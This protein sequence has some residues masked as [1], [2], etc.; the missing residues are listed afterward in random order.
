M[1]EI[2]CYYKGYSESNNR[3]DYLKYGLLNEYGNELERKDKEFYNED[4]I[5]KVFGNHKRS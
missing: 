1:K 5:I 4:K 3:I 2:N